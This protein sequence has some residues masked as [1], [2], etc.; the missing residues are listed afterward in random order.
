VASPTV[1]SVV[2]VPFPFSDLSASKLRP[3]LVL[4]ASDRGDWVCA[5]IT[6]NPYSDSKAIKLDTEDFGLGGLNRTSYARPGKLFTANEAL[7]RSSVGTLSK[8]KFLTVVDAVVALLRGA[9]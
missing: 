9:E 5:Q 8:S 7:F 2:S 3:A 1:G 6:S 4:A